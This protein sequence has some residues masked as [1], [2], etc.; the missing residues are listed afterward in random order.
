MT[1]EMILPLLRS[2]LIPLS[3][4]FILTLF[5]FRKKSTSLPFSLALGYGLGAGLLTQW[6]LFLGVGLVIIFAFLLN[7]NFFANTHVNWDLI[8]ALLSWL[9]F[10]LLVIMLNKEHEEE[11]KYLRRISQEQLAEIKLLRKDLKKK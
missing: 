9:I 5:L 4:G 2:L 3:L 8:N 7:A 11:L 10:V 6:M 1:I